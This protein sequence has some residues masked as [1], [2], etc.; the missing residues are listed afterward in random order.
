MYLAQK[1]V[2]LDKLV[3]VAKVQST[4][5]SNAI[6]GIFTSNTRL[7]QLICGHR[8]HKLNEIAV[9]INFGPLGQKLFF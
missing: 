9:K 4:E 8:D 1:P 2:V 6:E 5:S 3:E 7:N